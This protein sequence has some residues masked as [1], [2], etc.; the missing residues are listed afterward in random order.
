MDAV[1]DTPI[2]SGFF[3]A[4]GGLCD[5]APSACDQ[6]ESVR[7]TRAACWRANKNAAGR[8]GR[9]AFVL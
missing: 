5:E 1:H 7:Y 3:E 6:C 9:A 8:L 4:H 2:S